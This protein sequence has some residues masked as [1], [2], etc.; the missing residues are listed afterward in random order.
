[1]QNALNVPNKALR[2]QNEISASQLTQYHPAAEGKRWT[3]VSLVPFEHL[4]TR[5]LI[6]TQWIRSY[7]IQHLS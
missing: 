6:P 4:P 5:I 3:N 7:Q 2:T 1:M